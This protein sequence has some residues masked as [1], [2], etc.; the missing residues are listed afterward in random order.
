MVRGEEGKVSPKYVYYRARVEGRGSSV[1][2]G[3]M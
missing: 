2:E 1:S 3:E